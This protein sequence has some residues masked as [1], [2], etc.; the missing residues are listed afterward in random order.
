MENDRPFNVRLNMSVFPENEN[1]TRL[2]INRKLEK[3]ISIPN[4]NIKVARNILKKQQ[5]ERT[6]INLYIT[7]ANVGGG[8]IIFLILLYIIYKLKN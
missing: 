6:E 1:T 5:Q 7:Y 4:T 3:G 8:V 2:D